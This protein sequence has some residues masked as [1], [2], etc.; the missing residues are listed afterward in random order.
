MDELIEERPKAIRRSM[1]RP[2]LTLLFVGLCAWP[3]FR[4]FAHPSLFDDDFQRVGSLRRLTLGEALFRPFNEHMAPLFETISWLAWQSANH[5]VLNL[6]LAFQVSSYLAFIATVAMLALVV[7]RELRSLAATMVCIATFALSSVSAE[8]V[9]WYSASSFEWSAAAMLGAWYSAIRS[10]E[11]PGV[12]GRSAWLIGSSVASLAAPAFSAIGILAGPLATF[13]FLSNVDR[14][15]SSVQWAG[16]SLVPMIGIVAYLLICHQFAYGPILVSSVHQNLDLKSALWAAVQ[17][18]AGVLIPSLFGQEILVR[19]IP[20]MI[21]A[22]ANLLGLM[23]G[24]VAAFRSRA[25]ALILSSL[26]LIL[27]GYLATYA[28][29]TRSGD[30]AIFEVQR[31]HLFPS[32]GFSLLIAAISRPILRRFDS[33]KT[34][35]LL[36]ITSLTALLAI[37]QYPRM[38][39]ASARNF[40]YPDQPAALAATLRLEAVCDRE[41]ITLIQA[42]ENL[43][44]IQAPWFPKRGPFNP[45]LYLF[46]PGPKV[47]RTADVLVQSRLLTNLSI[48]DREVVCGGLNASRYR[49]AADF[50]DDRGSPTQAH[51]VGMKR[52]VSLGGNRYRAA[53]RGSRLDFE[54]EASAGSARS[55]ILPD[56]QTRNDIEIWWAGD[57]DVWSSYRSV[58]WTADPSSPGIALDRLPHWRTDFVRKLRLVFR[59][60]GPVQVGAPRFV[61]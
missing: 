51:R 58:R 22:G 32:I 18:P 46:G 35:L 29:R 48:E 59:E 56:L 3:Y 39:A 38:E 28:T 40:R 1:T 13:R 52:M 21:L 61:R 11:S 7:D 55:L 54:V 36:C 15:R 49:L 50:V 34:L 37:V 20:G 41:G 26:V 2:G 5:D 12:R 57:D 4:W 23:V 24:I 10:A 6:P 60:W 53:G 9:L 8:T 14:P 19:R 45:L 30:L 16:W 44:P 33:S 31:Y 27:G 25:R 43:D 47:S 17:A 42:M